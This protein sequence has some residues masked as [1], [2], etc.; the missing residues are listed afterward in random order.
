MDELLQSF[1]GVFVTTMTGVITYYL[2]VALSAGRRYL[3]TKASAEAI[4]I[5]DNTIENGV[6]WARSNG[7]DARAAGWLT[8][9]LTYTRGNIPD[10]LEREGVT[11]SQLV[12]KLEALKPYYQDRL[13]EEINRALG[14]GGPLGGMAAGK[15]LDRLEGAVN[16]KK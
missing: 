16:T 6:K 15:I 12:R 5:I 13:A 4:K 9:V 7:I 3:K 11:E 1:T 8:S 2:G 14:G 10:T